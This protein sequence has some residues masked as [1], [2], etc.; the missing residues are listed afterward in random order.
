MVFTGFF[1]HLPVSGFLSW[2]GL[3]ALIGIVFL[4]NYI[5]PHL[6]T[7]PTPS[8]TLIKLLNS[9]KIQQDGLHKQEEQVGKVRE[10]INAKWGEHFHC[11]CWYS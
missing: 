1:R 6:I 10:I 2:L 11:P 7:I 5:N 8:N 4:Y 9:T 3:H